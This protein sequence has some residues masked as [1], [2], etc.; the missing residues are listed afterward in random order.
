MTKSAAI[1]MLIAYDKKSKTLAQQIK[2][3]MEEIDKQH[4]LGILTQD[5]INELDDKFQQIKRQ[6]NALVLLQAEA[7]IELGFNQISFENN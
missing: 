4:N 3:V 7:E 2:D 1:N 6:T 5:A